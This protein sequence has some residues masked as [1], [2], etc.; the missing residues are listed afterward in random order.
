MGKDSMDKLET[1][2]GKILSK[3]DGSDVSNWAI[4]ENENVY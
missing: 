2:Y 4:N 1:C 3:I